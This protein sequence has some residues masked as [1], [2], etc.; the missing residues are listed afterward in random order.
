M[1]DSIEETLEH[2]PTLEIDLEAYPV[3]PH[4]SPFSPLIIMISFHYP[5]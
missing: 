2:P 1:N 4:N 5:Y 3:Y